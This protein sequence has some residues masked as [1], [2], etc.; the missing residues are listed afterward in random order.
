MA[1]VNIRS[2]SSYSFDTVRGSHRSDGS[3]KLIVGMMDIIL[4][5]DEWRKIRNDVENGMTLEDFR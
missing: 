4:S 2:Y 3:V 5:Q 1:T